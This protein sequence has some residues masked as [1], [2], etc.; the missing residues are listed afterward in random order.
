MEKSDA[1]FSSPQITNFNEECLDLDDILQEDFDFD[2]D[3]DFDSLVSN[4]QS[5]GSTP[6]TKESESLESKESPSGYIVEIEK[7][8]M[9]DNDSEE[10]LIKDCDTEVNRFMSDLIVDGPGSG[11]ESGKSEVP[12]PQSVAE[13]PA[14]VVEEL[15]DGEQMKKRRRQLRNRESAMQSRERRKMY[16]K[17]LEMKSNYL[18]AECRRLDS[19][20]RFYMSENLSLHQR[21]LMGGACA[22]KQESAVLLESLLLGSLFWLA[23]IVF[24]FLK[25]GLLIPNP[26]DAGRLERDLALIGGRSKAVSSKTSVTSSCSKSII[27]RRRCRGLK[28]RMKSIL[29]PVPV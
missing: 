2:F 24:L 20:L 28:T 25:Q 29:F 1:A 3:L 19:A 15:E 8:L 4:S 23:S 13:A 27:M 18:E 7:L 22:E 14:E 10:A 6:P 9:N 21:L 5:D 11:S 12:S 16:V 17:E 26:K